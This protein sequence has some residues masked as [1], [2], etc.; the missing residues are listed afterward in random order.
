MDPQR[1]AI[2]FSKKEDEVVG[3]QPFD[4]RSELQ[5]SAVRECR[6]VVTPTSKGDND[7]NNHAM[8]VKALHNIFTLTRSRVEPPSAYIRTSKEEFSLIAEELYALRAHDYKTNRLIVEVRR[9]HIARYRFTR[10]RYRFLLHELLANNYSLPERA[11]GEVFSPLLPV[12][13]TLSAPRRDYRA[14]ASAALWRSRAGGQL[15]IR[16]YGL[17]GGGLQEHRSLHGVDH[18]NGADRRGR[19]RCLAK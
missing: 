5:S 10:C 15:D 4:E 13:H 11:E 6:R 17:D 9:Y 1:R 3:K 2:S 18:S 8:H 7:E 12:A 16:N 14:Y 19:C